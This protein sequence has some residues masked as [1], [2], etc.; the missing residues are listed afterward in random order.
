MEFEGV[1][2]GE[3]DFKMLRMQNCYFIDKS[4]YIKD[5]ID[6]DSKVVLVTRPRRFGK[7]LNMS[8]LKYFFDCDSKDS[9]EL[10]KGLKIMEQGEKY[11]SQMGAYPCLYLTL[12]DVND[13]NYDN[14]ILNLKTAIMRMF[15]E[16][17]YLLDSDKIYADE[18]EK[19]ND[20]LFARI[21]EAMLKTSVLEISGYLNRHFS[22]PVMLFIDEYDVPIQATYINGY[23][24]K[25]IN[26]LKS[27]FGATFKDNPY[28]KK[29]V[30]TGVSRVAKE[31]IFSGANNFDVYTVLDNEFADDFGITSEEVEKALKDFG[32]EDQKEEVK[33]WYDGYRIGDV[34]E[35]YNPWSLLNFLAKKRFVPYWVN[36]SSND[37]I[38]LT[39]KNSVSVKEKMERLLKGEA[40]EVPIN[41]E[42]IIV[43]IENNEDNVWG[44]MLGTG[45]LKVVE[46]VNLEEGIYKVELPNYEIK[47]MF[48]EMVREWFKDKG[49]GNNLRDI[50]QDLVDLNLNEFERKFRVL[51]EEMF[52]YMD[53]GKNTAENFYH[54]FV[55][56]MLVG[57]KDSYYVNSNRESGFGRYDIMLEPQ[58]KSK[59]SFIIE[60]KVADEMSEPSLEQAVENGKKQIEEKDYENSLKA[61]GFRN[62]TKM[63]FAFKG[64]EFKISVL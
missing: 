58:D 29:T 3:S 64:K 36:T 33:R 55:L 41:L 57:L 51:V 10:F 6:N 22:K 25:A 46:T 31:S 26:F 54:A 44:L 13:S 35:I 43:G 34:E 42:T 5:I 14:M 49:I 18:K 16:H 38:K 15:G 27:F 7:T 1:G 61:R 24:E 12:K 60:F 28:L 11:T 52:S 48:Q 45:Y 4:M 63:V 59:N 17:R 62:I 40:I 56:G 9:K 19:I 37:L 30:L 47:L 8:M 32:V 39:M 50:L 23:Y 21:N 20:V 2:I 53:V